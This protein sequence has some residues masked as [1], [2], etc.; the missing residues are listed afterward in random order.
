MVMKAPV[1]LLALAD[2]EHQSGAELQV[3]GLC[4]FFVTYYLNLR[5]LLVWQMTEKKKP[6]QPLQMRTPAPL[7]WSELSILNAKPPFEVLVRI[8]GTEL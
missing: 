4:A 1:D 3:F 8:S 2:S 7:A 5:H 6:L